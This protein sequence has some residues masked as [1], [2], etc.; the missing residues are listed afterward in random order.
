MRD[1]REAV[2]VMEGRNKEDSRAGGLWMC[3]GKKI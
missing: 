1:M 2:G 3:K